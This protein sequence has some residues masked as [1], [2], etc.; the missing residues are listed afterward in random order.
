[1]ELGLK[2]SQGK[3]I[4]NSI[5]LEDG[6]ERFRAV[7]PLAQKLRRGARRRHD[8]RG[9]AGQAWASRASGSSRSRAGATR[10]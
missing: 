6:E 2:W 5:N 8:R 9:P 3:S 4:L 7:V 10:S 1:M